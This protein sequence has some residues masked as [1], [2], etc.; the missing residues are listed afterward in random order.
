MAKWQLTAS[1]QCKIVYIIEARPAEEA[2][3]R[4][5]NGE[6]DGNGDVDENSIDTESFD[7]I[8]EIKPKALEWEATPLG[9]VT[10]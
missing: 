1:A 4:W 7:S 10:Q 9:K 2:E 8:E 3:N 5:V 6:Y